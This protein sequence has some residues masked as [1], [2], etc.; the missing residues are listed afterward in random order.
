MPNREASRQ[1]VPRPQQARS[2]R[3]PHLDPETRATAAYP[4]REGLVS[5]FGPEAFR[6]HASLLGDHRLAHSANAGPRQAIAQALQ[7][8]HGNGYLNRLVG[9]ISPIAPGTFQPKLAAAL[10]TS[11]IKVQREFAKVQDDPGIDLDTE[12]QSGGHT[13][14]R[15]VG[16]EQDYIKGRIVEQGIDVASTYPDQ[17]TAQQTVNSAIKANKSDANSFIFDPTVGVNTTRAFRHTA[18]NDIGSYLAEGNVKDK[19]GRERKDKAMK[20]TKKAVAVL[21]KTATGAFLLTSFPEP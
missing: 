9:Q 12:E 20:R 17:A 11:E 5:G 8:Q 19:K 2:S 18:S 21:R 14:A 6:Q 7:R 4:L 10:P 13:V 15:H 1:R 3:P 16:K